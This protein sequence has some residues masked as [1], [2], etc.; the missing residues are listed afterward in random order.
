L[1]P[2]PAWCGFAAVAGCLAHACA[3]FHLHTA[4]VVGV[5]GLV[6][7]IARPAQRAARSVQ[8]GARSPMPW[9]SAAIVLLAATSA[10]VGWSAWR[11]Q[12]RDRAQLA[13]NALARLTA[14]S[15][16]DARALET[17]LAAQGAYDLPP[18]TAPV[19]LARRAV[20]ELVAITMTWPDDPAA[21]AQALTII[22][23]ALRAAPDSADS[24][25]PTL[26]RLVARWPEH[27]GFR[28]ALASQLSRRAHGDAALRPVALAQW[29]EV[30]A[31]Y[32][33]HLPFRAALAEIAERAGDAARAQDERREIDRLAPLV[34]ASNR[35]PGPRP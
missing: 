27:L 16:P 26:E 35:L 5:L 4:Q 1:P 25:G 8:P 28:A 19:E 15:G 24:W 18:T 32:P 29:C 6:I 11:G 33:T 22:R 14:D 10:G 20:D 21:A 3:D 17:L 13:A 7:A 31:R 9:A 30:V 12:E 34:H 2:A 23:H